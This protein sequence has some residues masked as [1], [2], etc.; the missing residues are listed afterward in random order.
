MIQDVP[1]SDDFYDTGKGLLGFSWDIAVDLL[2]N[3][4][5]AEYFGVEVAAVHD[6]YWKAAKRRLVIA[7]SIAQ[8]GVEFLLKGKT[9]SVSPLLLLSNEP[10]KW[11]SPYDGTPQRFSRFRTIDAQD[12]PRGQFTARFRLMSKSSK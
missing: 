4:K 5:D 6:A 1:A 11:P 3:L 8:Q 9:A 10:S 7:L 2:R 12:L